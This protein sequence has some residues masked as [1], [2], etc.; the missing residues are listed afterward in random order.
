MRVHVVGDRE[1][2]DWVSTVAG[3]QVNMTSSPKEASCLVVADGQTLPADVRPTMII[4]VLT[5]SESGLAEHESVGARTF[6]VAP[7]GLVV[8]GPHDRAALLRWL[9]VARILEEQ[10]RLQTVI[11]SPFSHDFRGA[12][13]VVQLASQL[14]GRNA[15]MSAVAQRL[16]SA[17][18]RLESLL[19]DLRFAGRVRGGRKEETEQGTFRSAVVQLR[20]WLESMHRQRVVHIEAPDPILDRVAP[21]DLD[22]V[23]RGVV[24][25][26]ARLTPPSGD[27]SLR[28][29]EWEGQLMLV[30]KA[31]LDA[32]SEELEMLLTRPIEEWS[33]SGLPGSVFRFVSAQLQIEACGGS[34]VL[35][36]ER[37]PTGDELLVA[38]AQLPA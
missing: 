4:D 14:A 13:S 35:S 6:G 19:R 16:N 20:G 26:V 7:R 32:S 37:A 33:L 23:L 8:R 36:R 10:F 34:A 17:A 21:T 31:P 27:V 9:S 11:S 5:S 28:L 22:L 12:L 25:A 24:D 15:A 38:S 1:T 2:I 3:E 18:F 29:S 30:A